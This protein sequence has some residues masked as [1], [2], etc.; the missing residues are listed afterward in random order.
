MKTQN[1]FLTKDADI[2]YLPFIGAVQSVIVFEF[3]SINN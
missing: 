3:V 1:L 2:I